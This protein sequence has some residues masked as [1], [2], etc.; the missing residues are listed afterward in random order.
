MDRF[1]SLDVAAAWLMA[2]AEHSR[3]QPPAFTKE[4]HKAYEPP[5]SEVDTYLDLLEDE[6]LV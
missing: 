6:E 4:M 2:W 1:P 3:A 5:Q